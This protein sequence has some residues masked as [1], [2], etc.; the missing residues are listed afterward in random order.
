MGEEQR[1]R[2]YVT[3]QQNQ[4]LELH[5]AERV[6]VLGAGEEAE[7][8]ED[9]LST[10]QL[11][12]LRQNRLITTREAADEAPAGEPAAEAPAGAAEAKRSAKKREG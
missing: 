12:A 11:G 3:N 8:R 10:P 1:V 4:P 6:I 5:L 9:E 2:Y 7:V